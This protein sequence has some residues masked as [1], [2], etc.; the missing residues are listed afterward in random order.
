MAMKARMILVTG[1]EPFGPYVVNPSGELAKAVD[2]RQIGGSDIRG[3]VLPVHH[4]HARGRILALLDELRPTA[5]LNLGLAAGRARIGLERI[6]VNVLDYPIPDNSGRKILDEPCVAGGPAGYVSTLPIRPILD[7]LT[8]EGIPAT[9][10]DSAGTY[11][12]NQTMY[13]TLHA[14][15]ERNLPVKAG[16]MHLPL[17]P[18]MVAASGLDEP[19][20]HFGLMLRAVEVALEVLVLPIASP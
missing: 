6:A 10:S 1:F 4:A 11:L 16:L 15:A 2:G 3:A 5:V 14:L 9:V 18:V 20:M 7:A 13:A 12:C 17:L 19:S 8:R